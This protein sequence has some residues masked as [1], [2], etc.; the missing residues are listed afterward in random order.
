MKVYESNTP[1]PRGRLLMVL[2]FVLAAAAIVVSVLVVNH[3]P[4]THDAYVFAFNAGMAPEVS[5]RIIALNVT[6]NVMVH[7]GDPLLVI[8]PEPFQL[9]LAQAQ[10]QV[11]ALRAQIDLTSRQ[12]TSQG[13]GA[14]AA[15]RQVDRASAQLT[16]ARS[17]LAR[18]Q[19]LLEPGYVTSQQ[20]DDAKGHEREA[21]AQLASAE[22]Q[23][24]QA[25]EAIGDVATLTAQLKAAEATEALAA[26]D[27]RLTTVTA[28]FDGRIVG[29][30]IAVG[31]FASAGQP[32][33]TLIDSGRWYAVA[34]FRETDLANIQPGAEATV[35][36]MGHEDRPIRGHVE[37]LGGGVQPQGT[38]GP[39]LPS[40]D[41]NLNW[42]VVA[43][44]FPVWIR[45][46][47]ASENIVRTGATASVRVS[48]GP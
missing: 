18:L 1:T 6:N 15:A 5:G 2:S 28:P 36:L 34:D 46:E 13:S 27:L 12:V 17:T 38:S 32:L 45:L 23:A 42:V 37:S 19:P 39:G 21:A 3:R 47:D 10:A 25:R 29:V 41:R 16:L 44:R 9:R 31:T 11:M 4:R 20:V 33:F 48:H 14:N 22:Q 8:D 30:N 24:S 40:V 43:Q 26:R 35:W 7:K